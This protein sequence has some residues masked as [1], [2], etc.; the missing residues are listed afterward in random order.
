[1]LV[2]L[3]ATASRAG[4][5]KLDVTVTASCAGLVLDAV[6]IHGAELLAADEVLDFSSR[7]LRRSEGAP[8][9]VFT[10]P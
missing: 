2:A 6:E 9:K 1:V 4:C 8:R 5:R 7:E 3:D 10:A